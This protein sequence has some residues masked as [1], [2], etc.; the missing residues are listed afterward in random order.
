[1]VEKLAVA[2]LFQTS[3]ETI[4]CVT[5]A[6]FLI[7]AENL[8]PFVGEKPERV[9]PMEFEDFSDIDVDFFLPGIPQAYEVRTLMESSLVNQ[10]E[11]FFFCGDEK[12]LLKVPKEGLE[13]LASLSEVATLGLSLDD[14]QKPN[15]ETGENH[16][17]FRLETVRSCK[18]HRQT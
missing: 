4:A 13:K 18:N 2:C 15:E 17:A 14:F 12:K 10:E 11:V 8:E 16:R 5:P 6:N 1:M 3:D 9:A 7:V